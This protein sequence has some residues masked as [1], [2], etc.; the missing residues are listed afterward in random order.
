MAFEIKSVTRVEKGET[1]TMPDGERQYHIASVATDFG[2]QL[3]VGRGDV[4]R[5]AD[6]TEESWL[7]RAIKRCSK[8]AYEINYKPGD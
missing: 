7:N 2:E 6:E 5:P 3:G 4:Y 1:V 8:V